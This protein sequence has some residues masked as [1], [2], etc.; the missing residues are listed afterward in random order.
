MKHSQ[1]RIRVPTDSWQV[2]WLR[3]AGQAWTRC[4]SCWGCCCPFWRRWIARCMRTSRPRGCSPS[5]ACP[6]TSPGLR[7]TCRS[8]RRRPASS[9][10]SS[11]P[12]RL[13]P[14]TPAL[15]SS[16]CAPLSQP[17][18]LLLQY[19]ISVVCHVVCLVSDRL[20]IT[21]GPADLAAEALFVCPVASGFGFATPVKNGICLRV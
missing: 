21:L 20:Q 15:P 8:W 7:T 9:T 13:C 2:M 14:S 1:R 5:S 19:L 3:C 10:S 17:T 12:T 18:P 6:G 16:S 4:W 11:P